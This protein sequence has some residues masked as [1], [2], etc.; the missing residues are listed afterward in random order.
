MLCCNYKAIYIGNELCGF[1]KDHEYQFELSNDGRTYE[2]SAVYDYTEDKPI[3]LYMRY[4]S[5][6]SIKRYWRIIE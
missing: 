1:Q 3:D 4:S 2:L 6:K 5:E